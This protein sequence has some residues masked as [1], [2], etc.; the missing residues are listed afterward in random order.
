MR[1]LTH[2][3]HTPRLTLEPVTPALALAAREGPAAFADVIGAHAPEDWCAG[4]LGLVARSVAAAPTRAIAIHRIEGVVIGDV[5]FEAPRR[6]Q[7]ELG[8]LEIGYAIAPTWRRQG[9]AVEASGAVID[10]LLSEGGSRTLLAGCDKDNIASVRTLR[11]LGFWLDG[12]PGRNFWW[13]LN[14]DL[15]LGAN[16]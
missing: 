13:R 14:A 16:A 15:R 10:W 2:K 5:R 8:D 3:L 7:A 6:A 9:Y 11:R 12:T 1:P 4:S